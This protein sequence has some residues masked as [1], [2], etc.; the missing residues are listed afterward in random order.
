MIAVRK[1]DGKTFI[2]AMAYV[3]EGEQIVSGIGIRNGKPFGGSRNMLAKGFTLID[4]AGI[5]S[6]AD[7]CNK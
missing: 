7:A 6:F 3:S 2:K 1:K 4:S 5:V